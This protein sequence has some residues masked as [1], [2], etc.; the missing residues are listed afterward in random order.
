[1][2]F[3]RATSH[4]PLLLRL[5][6]QFGYLLLFGG[7]V[8]VPN[9]LVAP[10]VMLVA[11]AV[12]AVLWLAGCL[13]VLAGVARCDEL[14]LCGAV[15]PVVLGLTQ[16]VYRLNFLYH[17]GLGGLSR[18]VSVTGFVLVWAAEIALVLVPGF[19]FVWWNARSLSSPPEPQDKRP[20]RT[21]KRT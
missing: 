6:L 9:F 1:M 17:E 16:L 21:S 14:I 3:M 11:A 20:S 15:S 19:L 4:P 18:S 7:F 8:L 13:G 2:T 12:L 5:G 10:S